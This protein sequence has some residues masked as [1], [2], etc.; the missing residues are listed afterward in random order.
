MQIGKLPKRI[1]LLVGKK[2]RKVLIFLESATDTRDIRAYKSLHYEGLSGNL[3]KLHSVRISGT[4]L[5]IIF[6][7]EGQTLTEVY[8]DDYH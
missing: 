5:R 8:L 1:D 6:R 7:V 4:G 2:I 3:E